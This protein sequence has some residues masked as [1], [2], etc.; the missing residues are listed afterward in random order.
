M[1]VDGK[2]VFP[3]YTELAPAV[4]RFFE[5]MDGEEYSDNAQRY[6]HPVKLQVAEEDAK[7]FISSIRVFKTAEL[8]SLLPQM[9]ALASLAVDT[10]TNT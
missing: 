10:P 6:F 3:I 8:S 7:A 9:K 1:V 5:I 4:T 2:W